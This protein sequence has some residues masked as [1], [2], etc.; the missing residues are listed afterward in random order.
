[1]CTTWPR[2]LDVNQRS[3]EG[4]PRPGT[5]DGERQ[6]THLEKR[7]RSLRLGATWC[8]VARAHRARDAF[9]A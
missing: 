1:M 4:S 7:V 3:H 2:A 6:G 9:V 5:G 8:D